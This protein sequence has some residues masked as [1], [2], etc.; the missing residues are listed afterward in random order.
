[1]RIV[2]ARIVDPTSGVYVS[3][4]SEYL[5]CMLLIISK[6]DALCN[7]Y[8]LRLLFVEFGGVLGPNINVLVF[9]EILIHTTLSS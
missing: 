3:C 1:M 6:A 5:S 9:P 7:I 8:V 2:L 4:S